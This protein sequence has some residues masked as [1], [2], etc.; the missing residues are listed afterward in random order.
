MLQPPRCNR[1]QFCLSITETA[2]ATIERRHCRCS[3]GKYCPKDIR[4]AHEEIKEE[5]GTLYNMKC[6]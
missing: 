1:K 5:S 3:S 4:L 6:I 2:D